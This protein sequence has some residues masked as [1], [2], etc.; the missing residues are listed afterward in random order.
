MGAVVAVV[1]VGG[2]KKLTSLTGYFSLGAGRMGEKQIFI[3]S[4]CV[5]SVPRFSSLPTL[6]AVSELL[7][8]YVTSKEFCIR[9]KKKKSNM[10][11][12]GEF[13]EKNLLF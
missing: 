13:S 2:G 8:P 1:A 3:I 5:P 4:G 7:P 10:R 12:C 11:T 6:T 9:K